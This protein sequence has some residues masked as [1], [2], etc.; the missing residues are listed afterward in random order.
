ML[1]EVGLATV[2]LQAYFLCLYFLEKTVNTGADSAGS[3]GEMPVC[4]HV[5]MV[6]S[7][8]GTVL[9]A[10]CAFAPASYVI[11]VELTVA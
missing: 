3:Q 2:N 1:F 6:Q 10:Y 7:T 9:V 8:L 4:L 5:F 11:I